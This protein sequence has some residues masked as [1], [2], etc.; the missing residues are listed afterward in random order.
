M[1]N[2]H[3]VT[4]SKADLKGKKSEV[5]QGKMKLNLQIC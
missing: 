3:W 2:I 5:K 4:E 1:K